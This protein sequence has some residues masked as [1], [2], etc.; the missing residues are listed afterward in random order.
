MEIYPSE[1]VFV[2]NSVAWV[3]LSGG[4]GGESLH[5][6]EGGWVG[7]QEAGKQDTWV[8]NVYNK[9]S[10]CTTVHSYWSDTE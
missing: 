3:V 2:Q 4:A 10:P 6:G 1:A 7:V 9:K 8:I 5:V